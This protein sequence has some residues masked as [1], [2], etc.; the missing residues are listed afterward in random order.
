MQFFFLVLRQEPNSIIGDLRLV[1]YTFVEIDR[2][3]EDF[4]KRK[5]EETGDYTS[6]E[7]TT[8]TT[9]LKKA[10]RKNR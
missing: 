9:V 5:T 7:Y 2:P 8:V 4:S 3:Q 6:K 10:E 1:Q